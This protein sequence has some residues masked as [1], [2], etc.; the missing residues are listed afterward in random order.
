LDFFE[1]KTND[2]LEIPKSFILSSS[3]SG[4]VEFSRVSYE[5]PS[6]FEYL[7]GELDIHNLSPYQS[8]VGSGSCRENDTL[9]ANGF[10]QRIPFLGS[11]AT[12]ND[13]PLIVS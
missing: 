6:L 8:Q 7:S 10:H 2:L 3:A 5:G 1:E 4:K 12:L 13:A 9:N 11:N